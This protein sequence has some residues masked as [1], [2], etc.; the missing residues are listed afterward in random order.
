MAKSDKKTGGAGAG[1]SRADQVRSAVDIAFQAAGE[2]IGRERALDLA[3]ELASAAHR[4]REALEELRPPSADDLKRIDKRL[5]VI[6]QRL[7]AL[8]SATE[9]KRAAAKT[10]PAARAA[11]PKPAV[12]KPAG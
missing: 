8:E 4:V 7:S 3:D 6:E 5:G 2:R 9:P 11:K 1:A 12:K 10:K